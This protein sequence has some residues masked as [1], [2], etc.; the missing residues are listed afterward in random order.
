MLEPASEPVSLWAPTAFAES[1]FQ[2]WC[3]AVSA[4]PSGTLPEA[5]V[6]FWTQAMAAVDTA[7]QRYLMPRATQPLGPNAADPVQE[8]A[9]QLVDGGISHG[10]GFESLQSTLAGLRRAFCQGGTANHNAGTCRIEV[11][12]EQLS[13]AVLNTY[14]DRQMGPAAHRLQQAVMIDW[15]TGL[16]N[17]TYLE[18]YLPRE[19][20][21]A[22]RYRRV[23]CVAILAMD[24]L[25]GLQR[26]CGEKCAESI[27]RHLA[28]LL[29]SQMRTSDVLVHLDS[30]RFAVVLVECVLPDAERACDRLRHKIAA[31]NFSGPGGRDLGVTL[32]A[33]IAQLYPTMHAADLVKRATGALED[34]LREGPNHQRV[35]RSAAA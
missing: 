25:A 16:Y 19:V 24:G 31:A 8:L 22:H 13:L 2:Q 5:D 34:A 26:L 35:C 20:A 1:T 33:G 12:F 29:R 32:C 7:L 27:L 14:L 11:F 18:D 6:Y 30:G 28:D 15:L 17:R 9:S 3:Q 10:V 4:G 23:F 21:R